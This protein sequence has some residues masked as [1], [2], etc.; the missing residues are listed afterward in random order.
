MMHRSKASVVHFTRD[1]IIQAA[2]PHS[3]AGLSQGIRAIRVDHAAPM[4]SQALLSEQI[5]PVRV[6]FNST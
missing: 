4:S 5:R 6:M 1:E 2:P 3:Q